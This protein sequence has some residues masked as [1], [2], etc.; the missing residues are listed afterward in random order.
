MSDETSIGTVEVTIAVDDAS[1]E[2]IADVAAR[3]EQA[4]LRDAHA[5]SRIGVITGSV[6]EPALTS[7]LEEVEG[8]AAVE[9]TRSFQLPPPDSPIQ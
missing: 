4:G 2:R 9:V 8:V 5:Q 3:L 6:D 1:V 7:A